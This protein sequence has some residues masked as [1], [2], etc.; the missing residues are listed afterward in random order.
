MWNFP[1]RVMALIKPVE[2]Y[3]RLFLSEV[4]TELST[5]PQPLLLLF[6]YIF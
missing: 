1:Q 3:S 4:V 2:T 5:Y 6:I